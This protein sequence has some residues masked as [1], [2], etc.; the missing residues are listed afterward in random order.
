MKT[1]LCYSFVLT[2]KCFGFD[3]EEGKTP[4]LLRRLAKEK[5]VNELP[6]PEGPM[7]SFHPGNILAKMQCKF[8]EVVKTTILEQDPPKHK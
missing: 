7:T 2:T 6:M 8:R 5:V 3:I 4:A 1:T